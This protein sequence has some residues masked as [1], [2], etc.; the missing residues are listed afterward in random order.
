M[1][2]NNPNKIYKKLELIKKLLLEKN[3]N[4]LKVYRRV[5]SVL[6]EANYY[7]F[8]YDFDIQWYVELYLKIIQIGLTVS[9]NLDVYRTSCQH[10]K[11]VIGP[12]ILFSTAQPT[13]LL[14]SMRL[15]ARWGIL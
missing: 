3:V 13:T 8:P 10:F 4:H 11:G 7:R 2:M 9:V 6:R 1:D 15:E 12:K 5:S 14:L